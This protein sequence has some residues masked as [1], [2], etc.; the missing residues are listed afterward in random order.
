MALKVSPRKMHKDYLNKIEESLEKEGIVAFDVT[1]N[2]NVNRDYLVL[3]HNITDIPSREL[4]EYLNAFTQQKMYTRTVLSRFNLVKEEKR[5][6]Y[7]EKSA[8]LYKELSHSK[9]SE[10]AKERIIQS[11]PEVKTC[12]ESYIDACQ[13]VTFLENTIENII[14]AIFLL[15][16]EV[17]RRNGD[18]NDEQRLSNI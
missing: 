13:K 9:Q 14:D 17:S 12:Y 3:P 6:L 5:R 15:S 11:D 2:L 1:T 4:G 7:F 18:F 16:R 10:T 8:S